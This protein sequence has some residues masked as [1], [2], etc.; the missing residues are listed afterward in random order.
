MRF[1]HTSSQSLCSFLE[2]QTMKLRDYRLFKLALLIFLFSVSILAQEKRSVVFRNVTLIDMRSEP[3][4]QNMTVVVEANRIGKIGKNIKIPKNAEVIDASGKFLI[5]GLW[6]MH[7]H[8]L[9]EGLKEPFMKLFIPNGVTGVRDLGGELLEQL[10]QIRQS[11]TEGKILGP[12]IV[13][14]GP[15]VDG[16]KPVWKFSIPVSNAEEGRK[17]VRTLKEKGADFVKVYSLLSR[18][19]YFAIADEANKQ[20]IPFAGHIPNAVTAVEASEAGQK[21]IEHIFIYLDVSSDE[22]EL[23][24]ERSEAEAKGQSEFN[25]V[26]AAQT[27]RILNTFSEEKVKLLA[28]R[29]ARNGTW[30]V[31]TLSLHRSLAFLN[32]SSFAEDSRLKYIPKAIKSYWKMQREQMP[33]EVIKR[34]RLYY[35]K[36]LQIVGLMNRRGAKLLAGSDMGNPY[37]YPGFSLHDEL[38]LLVEAGLTP[39]EALR[40]ATVNPAQFFG[41]EKE[42]G[43]IEKGKLADLVLLD[44]NPLADISNTRKINAV[45]VNGR[46]LK[47]ADLDEMLNKVA[48]SAKE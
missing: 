11:I 40:T 28:E 2:T 17:A 6:D 4:Q 19:S 25:K 7:S 24:R 18:D 20:K 12:R 27:S 39:L 33:E 42:F 26:R 1:R 8:F 10:S 14:A 38:A 5:P 13:A 45:V 15:I 16:P 22:K 35:T 21:S 41:K 43:T 30:F 47:R 34:N 23:R 44:A 48:E 29:F 37:V 3:P 36:D 9:F 46:L 31:P 32:D